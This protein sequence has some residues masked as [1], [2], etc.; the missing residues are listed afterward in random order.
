MFK[1][2]ENDTLRDEGLFTLQLFWLLLIYICIKLVKP[3]NILKCP[4][5]RPFLGRN[6]QTIMAI[7]N[8]K[9]A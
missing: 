7:Y 3:T 2:A 4:V 6:L 5:L 8:L 9:N 1:T